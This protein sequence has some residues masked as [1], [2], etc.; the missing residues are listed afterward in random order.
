M[1]LKHDPVRR[2][3]A[4]Q[5]PAD[6]ALMPQWWRQ[7]CTQLG[8]TLGIGKEGDSDTITVPDSTVLESRPDDDLD[9]VLENLSDTGD[10]GNAMEYVART[11][12]PAKD[13]VQ[14]ING[15]GTGIDTRLLPVAKTAN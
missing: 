15:L 5:P 14:R 9:G 3:M 2:L 1:P 13:L 4:M 6:P 8:I 12:I 7:V 11:G 10:I